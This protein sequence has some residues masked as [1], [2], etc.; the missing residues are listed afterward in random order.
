MKNLVWYACYGSNINYDRFLLYILGGK[1]EFYGV[2]VANTGAND[3]TPPIKDISYTFSH[4]IYFAK[5]KNRWHG[6]VAFLDTNRIGIAYGR[7]YLIT[8]EQFLEVKL[9]EGRWYDLE[10]D[11]GVFEGFQI[12]TF[13]GFHK[14]F[15]KP[16]MSYLNTI[17]EGLLQI[18]KDEND[19]DIH[20]EEILNRK[21]FHR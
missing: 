14:D 9:Q 15:A 12:K 13:T 5:E 8:Y 16:S 2:E 3:Q 20:I 10:I 11:L 21:T 19:I 18:K 17:K 7:A 4:P 1:K 6:G